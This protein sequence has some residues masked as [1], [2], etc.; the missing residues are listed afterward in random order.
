VLS[1]PYPHLFDI[2]E[3]VI[4]IIPFNHITFISFFRQSNFR[5]NPKRE[6]AEEVV[7]LGVAPASGLEVWAAASV[8]ALFQFLH[9][10]SS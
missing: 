6:V 1:P 8:A 5:R 2:D 3:F 7:A 10:Q 4:R 9:L